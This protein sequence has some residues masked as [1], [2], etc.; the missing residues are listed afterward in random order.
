M[1][2]EVLTDIKDIKVGD[3]IIDNDGKIKLVSQGNLKYNKFMGLTLFGDCYKLGTQKVC[4][5]IY[6][7]VV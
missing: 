4:K 2:I 1:W 7:K 3:T 5:L 6:K